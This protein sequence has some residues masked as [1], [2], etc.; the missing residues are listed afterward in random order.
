MTFG[1]GN[2][3]KGQENQEVIR[4]RG[5][6]VGLWGRAIAGLEALAAGGPDAYRVVSEVLGEVGRAGMAEAMAEKRRTG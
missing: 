5:V 6:I 4:L 2:L 3:S 1:L